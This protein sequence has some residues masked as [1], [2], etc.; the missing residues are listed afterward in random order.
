MTQP[1]LILRRFDGHPF[2]WASYR[3]AASKNEKTV[4]GPKI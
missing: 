4:T 3:P 2:K 1:I